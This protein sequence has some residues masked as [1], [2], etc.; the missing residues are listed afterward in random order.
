M[1]G[2]RERAAARPR[3]PGTKPRVSVQPPHPAAR[4]WGFLAVDRSPLL[5]VQAGR[6][7]ERQAV[8]RRQEGLGRRLQRVGG[9]AAA[10]LLLLLLSFGSVITLGIDGQRPPLQKE[11]GPRRPADRHP[12]PTAPPV[13]RRRIARAPRHA[14]HGAVPRRFCPANRHRVHGARPLLGRTKK[15]RSPT[16][17][18]Q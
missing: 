17:S 6:G 3:N 7:A 9:H 10:P 13:A 16:G 5:R 8:D 2:S 14:L 18:I 1:A 4:P 12:P 15:D 11:D